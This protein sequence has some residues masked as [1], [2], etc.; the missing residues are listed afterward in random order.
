MA[1]TLRRNKSLPLT[2]D[3]LDDNFEYLSSSLASITVSTSTGSFL[4]SGSFDGSSTVTLYSADTNYNLDLSTLSGGGG[5]SI[6]DL[7]NFTGSA[8]ISINALNAATGSYVYSGSFDGSTTLTLYS[9]D[10]NYSLDLS[11]LSG[12]GGSTDITDL[13]N[14]TGSAQISINAL[15][16]STGSYLTGADTGSFLYSGSYN[17]AASAITL[18]SAD[19]NYTLDLSG[20]AGGGGGFPITASDEGSDLTNSMSKIDFVG[21]AVTATNV[22][23]IVTVTINTG[24]AASA[25]DITDLNNFTGSAQISINALNA[26][27]GSYLT[28]ADTGSFVYSGSFDGSTTLTLY[29]AD[30]N[31]SLDLSALAGGGTPTDITA[32]NNFTGSAQISLDALNAAT[33]SYYY[34]SS[35]SNATITFNQ[36]DGTTEQVTIDNV[37]NAVSASYAPSLNIYTSD[38]ELTN[39]RT[40]TLGGNELIFVADQGE[41]FQISSDPA[42]EVLITDLATGTYGQV[43]GYNTATGQLVAMNTSSIAGGGAA[44]VDTGSFYY[45][46]SIASSTITFFQG[47]GTTES[48]TVPAPATAPAQVNSSAVYAESGTPFNVYDIPSTFTV[49]NLNSTNIE[50]AAPKTV[51]GD[52]DR[53]LAIATM[54]VGSANVGIQHCVFDYE[55]YN[56]TQASQVT[57]TS[58]KFTGYLLPYGEGAPTTTFTFT[59]PISTGVNVGDTLQLRVQPYNVSAYASSSL[60]YASLTLLDIE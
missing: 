48:V 20:L 36:G 32:L 37:V 14:F 38:G 46:S 35:V 3:E 1:L 15:N 10:T 9:A 4:Y 18:Y 11:A 39:T 19:S 56:D 44:A 23:S 49:V 21:N 28:G 54:E 51:T 31:Y 27:T 22:G 47:D 30:T 34:S 8:Q 24:S 25:T 26:A 53:L 42:S 45:S 16:A 6:T 57:G 5:V 59:C 40:V 13:N 2:H 58:G 50:V 60:H 12:G 41:T 29:S 7:N 52:S 43:I 55:I 17:S 33:G